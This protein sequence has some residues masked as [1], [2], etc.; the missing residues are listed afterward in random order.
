MSVYGRTLAHDNQ[1]R[2]TRTLALQ[3]T[4]TNSHNGIQARVCLRTRHQLWRAEANARSRGSSG[5][6]LRMTL[7]LPVYVHSACDRSRTAPGCE[8]DRS[9]NVYMWNAG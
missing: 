5:N 1:R 9:H 8:Q 3:L 6:K 4:T 7:G 2:R